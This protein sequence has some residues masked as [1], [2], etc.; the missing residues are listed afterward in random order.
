ME[1]RNEDLKKLMYEEHVKC[2]SCMIVKATSEDFPKVRQVKVKQ[3]H[4]IHRDSFLSSATSLQE[5]NHAV[6]F[7]DKCTGYRWIY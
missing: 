4:Q 6:V 7:V 5:Y 2:P 3:L 1:F